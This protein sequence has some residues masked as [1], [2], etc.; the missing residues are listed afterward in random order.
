MIPKLNHLDKINR[1]F[2]IGIEISSNVLPSFYRWVKNLLSRHCARAA[3]EKV[4][5]R[6]EQDYQLQAE[7]KL[8]LFYEYLEMGKIYNCS[9]K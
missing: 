4:T 5:P 9:Y 8:G 2:L 3:S 6:W 1:K 7:S